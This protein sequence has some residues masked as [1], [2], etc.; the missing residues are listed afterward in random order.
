MVQRLWRGGLG[1]L[2]FARRQTCCECGEHRASGFFDVDGGGAMKAIM[3]TLKERA[4]TFRC[5]VSARMPPFII[6]PAQQWRQLRSDIYSLASREAV[7]Q[8]MQGCQQNQIN[9]F[10]VMP[11]ETAH[12]V[13]DPGFCLGYSDAEILKGW[14]DYLP[15]YLAFSP[16]GGRACLREIK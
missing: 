5:G 12:D 4:S 8:C 6:E 2:E 10:A 9:P 13:I 1:A 14:H 11:A 16:Q 15:V 7:T 3:N